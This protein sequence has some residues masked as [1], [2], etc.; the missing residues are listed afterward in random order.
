MKYALSENGVVVHVLRVE[1]STI[2]PAERAAMYRKAP[3]GVDVGWL[4]DGKKFTAPPAPGLTVADFHAA[5]Y[6]HFDA[7]ARADNWDNRVTL[8]QRAAFE[9]HWQSLALEFCDWVNRCEVLALGLL[10]Q[11]QAGEIAPPA[12]TDEFISQLP[13]AP[14]Q[15]LKG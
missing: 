1:P 4:D 3:E 14:A 9:G 15:F 13:A 12:T 2:W 7:A 5:L 11:Y 6:E 8:M 10:A